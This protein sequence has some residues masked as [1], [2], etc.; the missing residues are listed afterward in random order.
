MSKHLHIM[1][2]EGDIAETVLLP[3]DPLRAKFIAENY[4][5]DAKCY[6]TVRGMY[7]Y[8]GKY[9]GKKVSV[10]PVPSPKLFHEG[11]D[12]IS[13]QTIDSF[14]ALLGVDQHIKILGK[15]YHVRHA[16]P[17]VPGTQIIT[18]QNGL[19]GPSGNR[20]RLIVIF[21]VEVPPSIT[22]RQRKYLRKCLKP[23]D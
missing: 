23:Q 19:Y 13:I 6:N 22:D 18:H 5:E 14:T 3:G 15:T 16:N 21:E 9:K 1:A 12:L 10:Q 17:I 2:N 4:L 20:G 8:T 7:G 11:L